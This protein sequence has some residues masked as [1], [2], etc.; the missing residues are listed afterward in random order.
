MTEVIER[1]SSFVTSCVAANSRS[2]LL[3]DNSGSIH[4]THD[5]RWEALDVGQ[6]ALNCD[7][8]VMD[9]GAKASCG[10]VICDNFGTFICWFSTKL[11]SCTILMAALWAIFHG[12]K[13]DWERGFCS[14]NYQVA[15]RFSRGY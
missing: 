8:S 9:H 4:G 15:I 1:I 6:V 14:F 11:G 12:L 13:L 2:D 3:V 5:I 7:V 10:G